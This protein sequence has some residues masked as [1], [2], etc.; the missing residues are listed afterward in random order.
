MQR[1]RTRN[2]GPGFRI[3][4]PVED[5]HPQPLCG[6]ELSAVAQQPTKDLENPDSCHNAVSNHVSPMDCAGANATL[7]GALFESRSARRAQQ[8]I[9]QRVGSTRHIS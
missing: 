6:I 7:A 3:A 8:A 5:H 2:A 4:Q 1:D 9:A